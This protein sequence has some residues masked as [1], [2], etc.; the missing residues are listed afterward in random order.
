[1]TGKLEFHKKSY[2]LILYAINNPFLPE[3]ENDE[4]KNRTNKYLPKW[5]NWHDE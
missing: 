4:K 3:I 1:M 5:K 2:T